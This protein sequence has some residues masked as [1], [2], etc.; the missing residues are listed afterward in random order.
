VTESNKEAVALYERFGFRLRHRF[1]AMALDT[2]Y[3]RPSIR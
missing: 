1:D 3:R 2:H